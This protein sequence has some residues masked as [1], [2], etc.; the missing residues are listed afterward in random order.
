MKIFQTIGAVN[1]TIGVLW[2]I[3]PLKFYSA[4]MSLFTPDISPPF[5]TGAVTTVT[6]LLLL[7]SLLF[8]LNGMTILVMGQRLDRIPE[9]KV[10]TETGEYKGR[11]SCAFKIQ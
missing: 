7:P 10:F 4:A 8:I 2:L 3:A 6:F 1:V 9:L 5:D 11:S